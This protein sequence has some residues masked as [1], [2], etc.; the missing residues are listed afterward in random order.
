MSTTKLFVHGFTPEQDEEQRKDIINNLFGGLGEVTN[1]AIIQNRE[2]GGLRNFCF[3]E[4][5]SA[6]AKQ[7]IAE[8]EGYQGDGFQLSVSEARPQEKSGGDRGGYKSNNGGGNFRADRP[9]RD[10]R[11]SGYSRG[12]NSNW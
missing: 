2:F 8:L 10:N 6:A 4:M 3:V 12:G 5:D 1:I 9:R 11:D 7:A